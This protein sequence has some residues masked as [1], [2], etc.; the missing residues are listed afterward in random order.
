MRLRVPWKT[1]EA[2][3]QASLEWVTWFN[4]HRLLNS[5]RYFPQV[6]VEVRE[7]RQLA[8]KHETEGSP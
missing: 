5:I 7:C 4:H 8:V 3:V 1:K 2:L 6:E